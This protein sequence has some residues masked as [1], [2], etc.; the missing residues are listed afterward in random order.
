[1]SL[2]RRATARDGA[3][4]RRPKHDFEVSGYSRLK[5]LGVG[6]FVSSATFTAGGRDW[7][8]RAYRNMRTASAYVSLAGIPVPATTPATAAMPK[9]KYTLSLVGRDG[10]PS[11]LWRARSPIRTYG[12]PQPTSWGINDLWYPKPLLRLSGCLAGDRLKIRC[13]LTVFVFTAPST[14][15]GATTPALAPPPELHGHLERAL[16]DGRGADVTFHV[17]GTAFR[18]H[19]VMLAARSP[20]FDAELFGPMAKKDDVVE[21]ADVEPAIFEMLLHFVYTDTLPPAIFDGDST[22]AAA[23]HLLVA[24]DR[25]GMERLK[26]MC[27]EKLCRSI[28]VSTVTT[29]LALADQHHCQELKEACLAFMSSPKVLRVVVASDEFKHLMASCPQLVSDNRRLFG[30]ASAGTDILAKNVAIYH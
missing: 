17:A 12:W 15:K 11:R 7:A 23:Q 8:V 4:R 24:A 18:A 2:H 5:A 6:Q 25:Y 20:V 21:I 30:S 26:I 22:A 14:T 19:R 3:T 27:A 29:T 1:M 10:R 9:A 28:D 13:E 16:G